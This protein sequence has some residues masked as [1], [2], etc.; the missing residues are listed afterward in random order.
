[1][2]RFPQNAVAPNA[3]AET[4]RDLGR[5]DEALVVFQETMRRFPQDEVAPTAYAETLRELGRHD[6]A[7]AVF[8]ETMRRFPQSE[9]TKSAYAHLLAD[10]GRL[11]EADEIL[12]KSVNRLQTH[13]DWINL[14]IYAMARL[15]DGRVGEALAEF[16]RGIAF[17]PFATDRRYFK[18]ARSLALINAK[19][20]EEAAHQLETLAKEPGLLREEATNVVLFRIHALAEAGRPRIAYEIFESARIFDF[21]AVKQKRLAAALDE[22][23]GLTTGVPAAD[24]KAQEL[25]K[26][27][28]DLEYEVIRPRLWKAPSRKVA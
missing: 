15:R 27:I 28:A 22:R 17:C 26:N 13:G 19:R 9:V 21:A 2:R 25:S 14:H 10:V 23:Y 20:A 11:Q 18:T 24:N 8:Q 5:H 6:E 4:L 12:L 3:Y 16:D 1:M 7:L